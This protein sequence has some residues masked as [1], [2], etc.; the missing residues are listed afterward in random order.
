MTRLSINFLTTTN[1]LAQME[2]KTPQWNALVFVAVAKRPTEAGQE[3]T[4][5]AQ[6]TRSC[7]GQLEWLLIKNLLRLIRFLVPRNDMFASR[8]LIIK[9]VNLRRIKKPLNY[10]WF[11]YLFWVVHFE[12]FHEFCGVIS[13]HIIGFIHQLT[14]KR[15]CSFDAFDVKLV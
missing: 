4:K 6:F 2:M 7:N 9:S 14:V 10:E 11:C 8:R 12:T 3:F 13:G 1:A 5:T 15:N